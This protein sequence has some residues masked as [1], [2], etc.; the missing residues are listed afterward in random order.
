MFRIHSHETLLF[1]CIYSVALDWK[2]LAFPSEQWWPLCHPIIR[3]SAGE[4]DITAIHQLFHSHSLTLSIFL[5]DVL[6]VLPLC[7]CLSHSSVT[8]Q[9]LSA[10][11]PTGSGRVAN[12]C[13]TCCLLPISQL[14]PPYNKTT[15][16]PYTVLYCIWYL[17]YCTLWSCVHENRWNLVLTQPNLADISHCFQEETLQCWR[18][19]N[20]GNSAQILKIR[21]NTEKCLLY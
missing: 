15:W 13:C 2:H 16:M 12:Y 8:S 6:L 3:L 17:I 18:C 20:T 14:P 7:A 10:L 5:S 4:Y 1:L 9:I 11:H 19:F 21:K